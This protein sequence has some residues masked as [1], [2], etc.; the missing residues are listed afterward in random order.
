MSLQY[1]YG[2]QIANFFEQQNSLATFF[3]NGFNYDCREDSLVLTLPRCTHADALYITGIY[4]YAD[5][6]IAR[7][8]AGHMIGAHTWNH[9]DITTL[10]ADQLNEQFTLVRRERHSTCRSLL[11]VLSQ[12]ET[13]LQKILGVVPRYFRPVSSPGRLLFCDVVLI[14]YSPTQPYGSY[15]DASLAII[16]SR[17]YQGPILRQ[18]GKAS[19]R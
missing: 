14:P 1:T 2:H 19:T 15:D 13:A 10:S 7:Y 5:E 17:G 16:E 8:N 3:V 4:N 6:L 11:I 18:C 9:A 12:L